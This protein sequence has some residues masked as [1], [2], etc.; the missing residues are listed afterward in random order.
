MTEPSVK[1]AKRTPAKTTVVYTDGAS[2]N[3]GKGHARAGYGVYWGDNDKRN[4]SK[5]LS[6]DRQTNQ[7]AE[8]TAVLHALKQSR[9][10]SD[11]LEI[12]TDSKYVIEGVTNWSKEWIKK[13]W[14]SSTGKDVQNRDLFEGILDEMKDRKVNF[15]YVPGHQGYEGN[16][17]ADKFAVR[18]A[19]LD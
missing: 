7:R 15:T 5:R 3:N 12:R 18:G 11:T 2:S 4:T 16:E 8:A 10:S 14:K 17:K 13:D 19:Q 1:Y 6:G 9:R